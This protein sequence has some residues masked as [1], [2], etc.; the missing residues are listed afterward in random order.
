MRPDLFSPTREEQAAAIEHRQRFVEDF[1]NQEVEP[2]ATGNT[3]PGE[4][5]KR[6]RRDAMMDF[7]APGL[8]IGDG[9]QGQ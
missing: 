9:P 1:M 4:N 5:T 6:T 2:A 7:L 8:V 3:V